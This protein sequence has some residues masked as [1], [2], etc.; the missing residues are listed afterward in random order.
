MRRWVSSIALCVLLLGGT[1][2][3]SWYLYDAETKRIDVEFQRD[4]GRRVSQ[5]DNELIKL[6]ATMRYWRKFYETSQPPIDPEQFR[7]V[8]KDVLKS[9]PSFQIIGWA[10][11]V[12]RAQRAA[13][14]RQFKRFNPQFSIFTIRPEMN[15]VK[16]DEQD[17]K[18]RNVV[19]PRAF[20][21]P[22]GEQSNYLPIAV[23]EPQERVGFLTGLDMSSVNSVSVAK[24]IERAR[25]SGS[26][27]IIGLPGLPSPFSPKHEPIVVA[28]VPIYLG[29]NFSKATRHD[30]LQGFIATIFSIDE[31]VHTASLADQPKGIGFQLLDMTGDGGLQVL[32]KYGEPI[33]KRMAYERPLADALGRRWTVVASPSNVYI[34]ERRSMVP[35]LIL[36]AGVILTALLL[37]YVIFIQRQTRLVRALVDKRTRELQIAN[38][39]LDQLAR[40]DPLTDVA[41][42]RHFNETLQHEWTRSI[43]ENTPLAL[44]LIDVDFFKRFNDHYGHLRGDDCL[45]IVAHAV[46]ASIRR[47]IDIVARYGGEEF[48]VILPNSGGE[49]TRVAERCRAAVAELNIAHLKS[50]V[51]SYVTVS[52]GI[53]SVIPND[54]I[55]LDSLVD[56]ADKGLYLAKEQGRNR[57]VYHTCQT[58]PFVV[59]S[60]DEKSISKVG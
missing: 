18:S 12:P 26:N 54:S 37:S 29:D 22:S 51:A 52:I 36:S 35:H 11:L 46:R 49:V 56:C 15:T 24:Q 25:D 59:D 28:L 30:A 4:I 53:S 16:V 21:A 41:N 39:K 17:I 38:E 44:M 14:E 1:A 2:T 23:L 48:A 10:P 34:A 45:R 13:F 32:S 20:F 3:L 19:D 7:S 42:R 27:D 58:R 60:T 33:Q 6:R 9:Y 40:I 5:L 55:T 31:L 50:D 8:A 57:V 43:R 47:P